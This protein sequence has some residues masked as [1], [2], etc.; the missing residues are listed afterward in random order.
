MTTDILDVLVVGAGPTGTALAIDLVRRGLDIRIIDKAAGSFEGSRAKGVQP[1]SLEL[2][3]DLGLLDTILAAGTTYP[4]LGIH[5]GPATIPWEM[6]P[7]SEPTSDVPH[8]NTWLIPQH[9]TDAALHARLKELGT[10]VEYTHE[11]V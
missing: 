4:R 6:F 7:P 8:P 3:D 1:R 2:L 10:A 11:L 9:R 5:L